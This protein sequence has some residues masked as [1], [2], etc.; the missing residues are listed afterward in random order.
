MMMNY[1]HHMGYVDKG[2]R[3]ASSYSTSRR[4]LKW[5]KKLLFYLLDPAIL[6]SYI[7]HSS[8]GG[9]K[10]SHTD[11]RFTL[12]SNMLAH[13]GPE[14][15]VPRTLGRQPKA[16]KL[17]ARLEV[18]GNKHWPTPSE[19][20]LRCRVCR[21]RG[22]TKKCSEIAVSVKWEFALRILLLKITTQR[23]SS[24][25]IICDLLKKNCGIKPIC[26]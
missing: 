20:Q 1:N 4:K 14:R 17:L 9:K 11:F 21:A 7:L 15:R 22:V 10:V 26:K 23:H 6:N 5:T 8:C 25:N 19:T 2:D 12:E 3:M 18:C 16:E 13:A 24:N